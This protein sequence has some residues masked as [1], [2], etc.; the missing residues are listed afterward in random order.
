MLIRDVSGEDKDFGRSNET[1]GKLTALRLGFWNDQAISCM[2]A[3]PSK[4]KIRDRVKW[5]ETSY[6]DSSSVR[7]DRHGVNEAIEGALHYALPCHGRVHGI[8]SR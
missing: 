8:V 7:G 4:I 2:T 6:P 3:G 1:S 5:R